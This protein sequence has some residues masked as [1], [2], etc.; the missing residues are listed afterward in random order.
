VAPVGLSRRSGKLALTKGLSA[1]RFVDALVLTTPGLVPAVGY[2]ALEKVQ[3]ASAMMTA[4]RVRSIFGA[5]ARAI[6]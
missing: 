1:P 5:A 2:G 4:D 6:G 3:I